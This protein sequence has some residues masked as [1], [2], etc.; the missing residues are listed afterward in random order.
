VVLSSVAILVILQV[1]LGCGEKNQVDPMA[2]KT[3]ASMY[4]L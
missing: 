1:M 3:A 4:T 2:E